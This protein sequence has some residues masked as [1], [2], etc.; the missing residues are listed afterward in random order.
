MS[1]EVTPDL[2]G[3]TR[4]LRRVLWIQALR[5]FLYGFA[6]VLLGVTLAAGGLTAFEVGLVFTAILVG[7]AFTSTVVGFGAHRV[8]WRRAYIGLLIV[9]GA[10]GS[11][12]ALTSHPI[13]LIL[14]ALTGTLSTDPN[15]SGPITSLE[16]GMIGQ[17]SPE[18]RLR[19][20]GRYNAIAYLA[21]ALGSL[22]AGVP[23]LLRGHGVDLP[24]DRW[25]FLLFPLVACLCAWLASRLSESVDTERVDRGVA[26]AT[27]ASSRTV[28][29]KLGALFSMDAFAGGFVVQAFVVFW[30]GRAFDAST[31]L[32]GV[33]FFA[34]GLLQAASSIAAG[35]LGAR[36]GLLNTMVF[37][38]LPSNI[39]LMAVPLAPALPV[40]IA[41]WL[42][43]C[44]LSQ[45]DVPTRQAYIVAM[46]EPD[47]RVAAAAFTNTARYVARPLGPALAGGLMQAVSIGAPFLVAGGLKVVYDLLIYSTFRKVR[48]PES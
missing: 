4:D 17:A 44:T 11:V 27:L 21:G 2:G 19:V 12:F 20:F 43:R 40:A 14:V 23:A 5:A 48:L 13:A 22:C 3:V 29:V 31:E 18:A 28:V 34:S 1:D 6:S 25:F 35:R 16:Q 41:L 15:E 30:F 33:V 24:R 39:L 42:A 32:M 26:R 38:H 9:M 10:A 46:V 7:M 47:E 36:F 45:M 8:G 37:S